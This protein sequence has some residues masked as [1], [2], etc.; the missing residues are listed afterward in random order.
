MGSSSCAGS[1][2]FSTRD[3]TH[4]QPENI[5]FPCIEMSRQ[6]LAYGGHTSIEVWVLTLRPYPSTGL[7]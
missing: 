3:N 6:S 5:Q 7:P 2:H 4:K 1:I